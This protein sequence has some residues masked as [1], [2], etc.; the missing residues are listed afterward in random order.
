M[1]PKNSNSNRNFDVRIH[2]KQYLLTLKNLIQT[3]W[4]SRI[5]VFLKVV[6]WKYAA[7]L[8]DNTH[9]EVRFQ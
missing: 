7:N 4:G 9:A 8:Q 2:S 5:V 6:F 1:I 3:V